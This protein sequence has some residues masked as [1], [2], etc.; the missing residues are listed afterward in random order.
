MSPCSRT[1]L[2]ET[3]VFSDRA[4]RPVPLPKVD[5]DFYRAQ[6]EDSAP[7]AYNSMEASEEASAGLQL[8]QDIQQA[9]PQPARRRLRGV[10]RWG[11]SLG[12]TPGGSGALGR[13][14]LGEPSAEAAA[15]ASRQVVIGADRISEQH[16]EASQ[17][18]T[19]KIG[20]IGKLQRASAKQVRSFLIN[21][22]YMYQ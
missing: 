16:G 14:P 7:D 10:D 2:N 13:R 20:D 5:S 6:Q 19:F 17:W 3:H 18:E 1:A 9:Q 21:I 4:I 12:Y 8:L 15:E 11:G 22:F